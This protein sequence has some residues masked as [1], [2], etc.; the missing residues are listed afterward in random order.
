MGKRPPKI[1]FKCIA[2]VQLVGTYSSCRIDYPL[3]I[4]KLRLGFS[5]LTRLSHAAALMSYHISQ[6]PTAWT[7]QAEAA[8]TTAAK[9]GGIRKSTFDF[10]TVWAGRH[11]TS[12]GLS[13]GNLKYF[14]WRS[15][16]ARENSVNGDKPKVN[17]NSGLTDATVTTVARNIVQKMVYTKSGSRIKILHRSTHA[18]NPLETFHKTSEV[19]VGKAMSDPSS[20]AAQNRLIILNCI[21]AISWSLHTEWTARF[22]IKLAS[23]LPTV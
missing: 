7:K 13:N 20:S 3:I 19:F 14:P 5:I 23:F 16:H 22:L 21:R 6:R 2:Y 18:F 11:M 4:Q 12:P 17:A 1:I 15:S 8:T 10:P 9:M